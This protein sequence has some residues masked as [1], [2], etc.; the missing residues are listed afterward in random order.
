VTAGRCLAAMAALALA[1]CAMA[2]SA[3]VLRHPETGDPALE[4]EIPD[5][6][7]TTK[8]G[9]TRLTLD[10]AD[11]TVMLGLNV[12]PSSEPLETLAQSV[13]VDMKLNPIPDSRPASIAGHAGI[14]YNLTA[15]NSGKSRIYITLILVHID[16]THVVNALIILAV[17]TRAETR[18]T[19]TSIVQ[20]LRIATA[21]H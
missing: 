10:S 16:A 14:S 19:A 11:K 15:T 2:A 17:G 1:F 8:Q 5:G 4:V 7:T 12:F 20:N 6:W 18:Q 3:R 9:S 21:A 13:F